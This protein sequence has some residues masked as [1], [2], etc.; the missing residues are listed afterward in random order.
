MS[1]KNPGAGWYFSIHT[2]SGCGISSGTSTRGPFENELERFEEMAKHIK[3]GSTI[4]TYR[5]HEDGSEKEGV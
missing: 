4:T 2:M 5:I 1:A 3:A